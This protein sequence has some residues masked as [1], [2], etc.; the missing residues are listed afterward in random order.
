MRRSDVQEKYSCDIVSFPPKGN[1]KTND[2]LPVEFIGDV[3]VDYLNRTTHPE[4]PYV[5]QY[6]PADGRCQYHALYVLLKLYNLKSHL[7]PEP[8]TEP[9]SSQNLKTKL[10]KYLYIYI[11][12]IFLFHNCMNNSH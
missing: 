6:V 5:Y 11:C 10:L 3:A 9:T 1:G 8:F 7:V 2:D 4:V 12:V